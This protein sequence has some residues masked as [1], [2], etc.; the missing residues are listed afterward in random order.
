MYI[1][2][3]RL[4]AVS[5]RASGFGGDHHIPVPEP[6]VPQPDVVRTQEY[7]EDSLGSQNMTSGI[8]NVKPLICASSLFSDFGKNSNYFCG[9][10]WLYGTYFGCFWGFMVDYKAVEMVPFL[11]LG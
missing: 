5:F 7:I 9:C 2:I 3:Q 4:R 8:A 1:H 10:E 11:P 6:E